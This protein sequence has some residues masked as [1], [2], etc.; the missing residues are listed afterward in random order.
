MT[1]S[2]SR[3]GIHLD[4]GWA[5][6][7]SE[8]HILKHDGVQTAVFKLQNWLDTDRSLLEELDLGESAEWSK[9][10]IF[11]VFR[12]SKGHNLLGEVDSLPITFS[13][14]AKENDF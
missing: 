1:Q 9:S 4:G 8:L 5:A 7:S 6:V 10:A 12:F 2:D 3:E 14:L 13:R 11:V